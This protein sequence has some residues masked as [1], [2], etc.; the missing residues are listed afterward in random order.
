MVSTAGLERLI[1]AAE[2]GA[3]APPSLAFTPTGRVKRGSVLS[4]PRLT[5]RVG[6]APRLAHCGVIGTSFARRRGPYR[7]DRTD[8]EPAVPVVPL[9]LWSHRKTGPTAIAPDARPART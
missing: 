1:E 3:M 9:R 6:A 5:L 8:Q 2:D 4:A 7:E